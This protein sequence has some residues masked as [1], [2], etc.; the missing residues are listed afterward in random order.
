MF[1]IDPTV[2]VL[3][4]ASMYS[5]LPA[6]TADKAT[7]SVD[8]SAAEDMFTAPLKS[9]PLANDPEIVLVRVNGKEI[10]RGEI[11]HLMNLYMQ[12][13]GSRIPPSQMQQQKQLLFQRIKSDLIDRTLV[14]E[15]VAS[16]DVKVDQAEIDELIENFKRSLPEGKTFAELLEDQGSTM[17]ELVEGLRQQCARRNFLS[18]KTTNVAVATEA[19]ARIFYDEN[20]DN[21][22]RPEAVSASHVLLVTSADESAKEK[23]AK[24]AKL[25]K[26]RASIIAGELSFAKAAKKHSGC[27][28]SEQGGALGT[29]SKG[30]MVPEFEMAAFT[31]EI[32]EVGDIIETQHGY[33]IIK[34]SK[35]TEE[36]VTSFEEAKDQIV[37]YLSTQKKQQAIADYVRSLRDGATIEDFSL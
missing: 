25:E 30:R 4:I 36:G 35:H 12:Q 32:D 27:P 37:A 8:L 6:S 24:K 14:E 26:I 23:A 10:L 16:S 31:Q 17:P 33:H 2:G 7:Q 22:Q 9:D 18:L 11:M 15:A 21:F 13:L 3:V 19:E 1:K 20:P 29:F 5:S 28:S 34:V